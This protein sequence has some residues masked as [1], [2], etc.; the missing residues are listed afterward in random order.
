MES[1]S[2]PSSGFY[3]L[4]DGGSCSLS[5]SCTSVYSECLSSSQTSL[6]LLP[7]SPPSLYIDPPP[8][9]DV[10]RCRSAD[11]CTAHPSPPRGT[12]LLLGSSRIRASATGSDQGRPRPV[13]T[14]DLDRMVAQGLGCYKSLDPKK[15]P[16]CLNFKPPTV[17]PRFQCK[18]ES[19]SGN[20]VYYYPSP[21][22]AVALQSPIFSQGSEMGTPGLLEGQEPPANSYGNP[23]RTQI[24]Y[25]SKTP[26]YVDKLLQRSFNNVQSDKCS[27]TLEP[28]NNCYR[29]NSEVI[30]ISQKDWSE[31]QSPQ[32]KTTNNIPP[33]HDQRR[34]CLTYSS[35]EGADNTTHNL[36]ARPPRVLHPYSHPATMK[37]Y[38]SDE[39]NNL[40]LKSSDKPQ[41]ELRSVAKGSSEN[42]WRDNPESRPIERKSHRQ[43]PAMAHSS[44]TEESHSFEV[45]SNHTALPEFVHAKFLPAGYQKDKAKQANRKTKAAKLKR[46]SSEKQ[47]AAR[48][49]RGESFGGRARDTSIGR[50]G[51]QRKSGKGKVT[52]KFTTYH[53]IEQKH[54]SGSDSSLYSPGLNSITVQSKMHPIPTVGKFSRSHGAQSLEYDQTVEQR[55]RRQMT[56]KWPSDM[57]TFQSQNAQCQRS[58]DCCALAPGSM[59]MV[60]STSAKS[61]QWITLAQPFQSTVSSNSYLHSLNARYPPA[62]FHVPSNYPPRCESEYSAECASLF[63]STIAESSEGEMSDNTTNRFGDSESSQ[64]FQSLSDTDSCMSLDEGGQV[65][66]HGEEGELM[67]ADTTPRHTTI[68]GWSVKQLPQRPEPSACR[69]KASRALKKKIRRFQPASLKVMTLV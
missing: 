10:C 18:L 57:N 4:S 62:P 67:W 25:E 12:G 20:E 17:D 69:I 22:H 14:G 41:L 35:H 63:H 61:G 15:P 66:C 59:Q 29:K 55:K 30:A 13:S 68:V 23:Q 33:D 45:R 47:R 8:Q 43:R 6:L 52:Q 56:V 50:K 48:Q 36:S 1:D 38:S 40:S 54:G 34:H 51:E 21:L 65:D 58:K 9:V 44:S 31:M 42:Q 28:I 64:S 49:Q 60:R 7:M 32:V 16:M 5:N 37:D 24:G 26:G 53:T 3:E 27:E 39:V 11:E 19:H 46:K 2:R